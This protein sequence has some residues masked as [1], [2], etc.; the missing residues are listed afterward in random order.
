MGESKRR[1]YR[2]G[3]RKLIVMADVSRHFFQFKLPDGNIK[4]KTCA[5]GL[6][7]MFLGMI[8]LSYALTEFIIVWNRTSYTILEQ[9]DENSLTYEKFSF[10]RKNG[11]AI[12]AAVVGSTV[13]DLDP[14]VGQL[15]FIMKSWTTSTE[16]LKFIDIPSRPCQRNDFIGSSEVEGETSA[17]GFHPMDEATTTI[18][19]ESSYHLRCI[20]DQYEI[21]G[22]FNSNAASNLMVTFEVCDP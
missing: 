5:G 7:T 10:G 2:L 4:F 11:F 3:F 8:V 19:L 17:Y 13:D 22:D 18:V 21:K 6:V 20:E 9:S 14:E 1:S 15:K 16:E 12:A